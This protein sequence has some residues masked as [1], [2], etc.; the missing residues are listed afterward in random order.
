MTPQV[1]LTGPGTVMA[2]VV[3]QSAFVDDSLTTESVSLLDR[4]N[5]PRKT[6]LNA[7]ATWR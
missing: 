5:R 4:H 3:L 6:L 2:S 1:T 7:L